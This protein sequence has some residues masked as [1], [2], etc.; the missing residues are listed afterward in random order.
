MHATRFIAQKEVLYNLDEFN[1]DH[2][3]LIPSES[4][5]LNHEK[6][7][8]SYRYQNGRMGPLRINTPTLKIVACHTNCC[9]FEHGKVGDPYSN[10]TELNK[11]QNVMKSI[12]DRVRQLI[13]EDQL[14]NAGAAVFTLRSPY[15]PFD[16]IEPQPRLLV[17]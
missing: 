13:A 16:I 1:P 5:F 15:K 3:R 6:R 2:L 14:W 10:E 9:S 8:L 7:T 17:W 4:K 12:D 11:F